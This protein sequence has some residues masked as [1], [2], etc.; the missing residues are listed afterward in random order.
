MVLGPLSTD[1][2]SRWRACYASP[3]RLPD[4]RPR[5]K[6]TALT[7]LRQLRMRVYQS[8]RLNRQEF[9]RRQALGHH[10]VEGWRRRGEPEAELDALVAWLQHAI[11]LTSQ[12]SPTPLMAYAPPAL[13]PSDRPSVP[14]TSVPATDSP[15]SMRFRD[16][17]GIEP[18]ELPATKTNASAS[19]PA[20]LPPSDAATADGTTAD[21][22]ASAGV[23][24]TESVAPLAP[25]GNR[26][27]L[28]KVPRDP[29]KNL[30]IPADGR[31][32]ATT[33]GPLDRRLARKIPLT[34]R[35]GFAP[36]GE[37]PPITHAPFEPIPMW[38][39]QATSLPKE[40]HLPSISYRRGLPP[41]WL[42]AELADLPGSPEPL[43][44]IDAQE[45]LPE[46]AGTEDHLQN[47]PP[48]TSVQVPEIDLDVLEAKTRHYNLSLAGLESELAQV[49]PWDVKRL[50]PVADSLQHTMDT[51]AHLLLF[52]DALRPELRRGLEPVLDPAEALAQFAQRM[53]EV[54]I[55]H[56]DQAR[57]GDATLDT[58]T[59][60]QLAELVA[61]FQSWTRSK[62]D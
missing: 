42:Q 62:R 55:H 37:L 18:P 40:E 60:E 31:H 45:P 32:P 23:F 57:R 25:P 15:E 38:R 8:Y 21:R 44:V 39:R 30:S 26:P 3:V 2:S 19:L 29:S 4:E 7:I 61:R 41:N 34:E 6:P 50:Q 17:V 28:A 47:T 48:H 56:A 9:D 10:A 11:L 5:N 12:R 14:A 52:H 1:T 53:F 33:Q 54:R 58:Q 36:S 22:A 49:G 20:E 35:Q 43:S 24:S 13:E 16:T 59:H 46:R 51:R 27:G